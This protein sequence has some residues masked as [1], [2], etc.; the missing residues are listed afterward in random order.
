MR[1][2]S[3]LPSATEIVYAL[4]LADS[5]VG[6]TFECD[7][8]AEARLKP[9]VVE[10]R[11]RTVS[12]QAAI[13]A[14]VSEFM[15]RGESLYRVNSEK[16]RELRPDLVITQDLCHVCAASPDDLAPAISRLD[17]KPRV[18][19]LSPRT[20]D[21]VWSNILTVGEATE[22]GA[23]ARGLLAQI[24][25]RIARIRD[26]EQNE[27]SRPR[28]LCLE[29]FDPPFIAGHWVPEMV[30]LAGGEDVLGKAG[31]PGF[32]STWE[33]I[34]SAEPEIIVAMPCG[35]HLDGA[36]G[37]YR[38]LHFPPA[39]ADTPTA[40]EGRVYAV[41]ASSYFSRPGPRLATG[42]EILA[43]IF[44]PEGARVNL[45]SDAVERLA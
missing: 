4:G 3:F 9:V 29:W 12:G 26:A 33:A 14:E 40:A 16:L 6:V 31:E 44:R 43:Q 41:D 38:S 25:R 39:L 24:E 30:A 2:C 21:E 17:P 20:L 28:V 18:L 1:I 35:Y 23:E 10:S 7:F 36:V 11:M 37:E 45:P 5:L 19:D 15:A 8:P 27:S 32:R 22:R 34:C 13:D 42:M